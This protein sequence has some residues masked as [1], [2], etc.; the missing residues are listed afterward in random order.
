M[1][2]ISYC[3]GSCEGQL[4]YCHHFIPVKTIKKDG[5]IK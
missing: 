2:R 4:I 3:I 1:N 5:G